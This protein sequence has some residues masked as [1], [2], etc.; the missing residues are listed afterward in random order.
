MFILAAFFSMAPKK[1]Q[2]FWQRAYK[3]GGQKLDDNR[4]VGTEKKS[5][6]SSMKSR[7]QRR[8]FRSAWMEGAL[9]G[10]RRCGQLGMSWAQYKKLVSGKK[11]GDPSSESEAEQQPA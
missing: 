3:Y 9:D 11:P 5:K 8:H 10:A 1:K 2:P 7:E 4:V 6:P